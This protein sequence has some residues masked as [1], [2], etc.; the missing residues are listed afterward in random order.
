MNR[1]AKSSENWKKEIIMKLYANKPE[2]I[3][4]EE[5]CREI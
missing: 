3:G 4:K 1:V 5:N 2:H